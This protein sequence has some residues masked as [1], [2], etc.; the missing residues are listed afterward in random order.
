M[1]INKK[2]LLKKIILIILFLY[3][4]IL[5]SQTSAQKYFELLFN[6][7]QFI[8]GY[9]EGK[10]TIL[11][12]LQK[13]QIFDFVMLKKNQSI[14][15]E[16]LKEERLQFRFLCKNETQTIYFYD[17]RRDVLKQYKENA[18]LKPWNH[19]PIFLF[20]NI[21][22]EYLI[23]PHRIE[24]FNNEF[25]INGRFFFP[26]VKNTASIHFGKDLNYKKVI[27]NNDQNAIEYRIYFFY[28]EPISMMENQR[29]VPKKE[30]FFTKIEVIHAT[31]NSVVD[32]EWL[33]FN[34]NYKIDDI[35]LMPDF[36]SR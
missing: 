9:Y 25:F 28:D 16:I 4:N 13:K 15:W 32:I 27:M 24:E 33:Y 3:F 35:R 23:D 11:L 26:E 12:P 6:K 30:K 17:K 31:N 2:K 8:D 21:S 20:C 7:N 10:I 22:W 29:I 1:A 36:I 18:I 5:W 14:L 34:P 19:F